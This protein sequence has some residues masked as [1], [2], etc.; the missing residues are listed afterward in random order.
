MTPLAA[1]RPWL[2]SALSLAFFAVL[3][4]FGWRYART[5]AWPQVLRA[6]TATP[7]PTLA[8]AGALAALSHAIYSSFDLLGRAYTGHRLRTAPVLCITFISYAFN[9]NLGSLVGGIALRL[10][11]Y[12]QRGLSYLTVTRLFSLSI[13]TNWVGFLVLAGSLFVLVPPQPPPAWPL[14]G[15]E[16][17]GLGLLLLSLAAA[18]AGASLAARR[19][20]VRVLRHVFRLPSPG[21]V[22]AQISLSCAHWLSM[23]AVIYLLL[24]GQL[25]YLAVMGVLLVAAVAGV[26]THI[27]AGLGVTEAVF[28]AMLSHT[29]P[30]PSLLAALLAYRAIFYLVPFGAAVILFL[31]LELRRSGAAQSRSA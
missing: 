6:L 26:V 5:I 19:R 20:R 4:Y 24:Q 14:T 25:A 8:A 10:R 9:L 31:V 12:T 15:L 13:V 27:P 28:I 23:G 11:L 18:Y 7:W 22:A 30:A 1:A 2:V 3:V 29:V 17:R 21:M 16:L